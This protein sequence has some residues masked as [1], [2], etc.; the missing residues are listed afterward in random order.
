M[1]II[2]LAQSETLPAQNETGDVSVVTNEVDDRQQPGELQRPWASSDNCAL[3]KLVVLGHPGSGKTAMVTQ[4]CL[5]HFVETYD[6][7]IEDSYRKQVVVDGQ[8]CM[9]EVLDTA[10]HEEYTALRDQ[11]IRD[12]EGFIIEYSISSRRAFKEVRRFH[13]QVMRVKG[14]QSAISSIS[15]SEGLPEDL[16]PPVVLVG[17]KCDKIT[18]R[19]VSTKE[20]YDL[21]REMEC[22]FV[23]CSAKNSI[24]D[25]KTFYDVV[26]ALRQQQR[27]ATPRSWWLTRPGEKPESPPTTVFGGLV[28]R[29]KGAA[30]R[31]FKD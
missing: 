18:E 29:V 17:N 16:P 21:A 24:N 27:V 7:T 20:G 8:P 14:M 28:D 1:E 6:P 15:R 25:E 23:K 11:W 22:E 13:T 12:A 26:R 3:Y 5:N 2:R 19:E 31:V 10:G 4:F 9:I 30:R